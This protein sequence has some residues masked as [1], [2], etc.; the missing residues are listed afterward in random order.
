MPDSNAMSHHR[1]QGYAAH[2]DEVSPALPRHVPASDTTHHAHTVAGMRQS[3]MS[4]PM[5]SPTYRR[6]VSHDHATT[7]QPKRV[8]RYYCVEPST[9]PRKAP[10]PWF[11]QWTAW[12]A[13]GIIVSFSML[14]LAT[15]L[16]AAVRMFQP[17]VKVISIR[18]DLGI[19]PL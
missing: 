6:Q 13:V 1:Q 10:R 5:S 9:L 4:S 17:A 15:A 7:A 11:S 3:T 12:H 19:N 14:L 8:V 18:V 16:I 2:G